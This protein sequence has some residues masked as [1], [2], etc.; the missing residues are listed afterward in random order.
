MLQT[1]SVAGRKSGVIMI[2]LDTTDRAIMTPIN[3][4]YAV[5][6]SEVSLINCAQKYF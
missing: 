1:G 3:R 6:T 4:K 5:S 2:I